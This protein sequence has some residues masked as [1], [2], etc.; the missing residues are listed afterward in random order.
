MSEM[1]S[2][3]VVPVPRVKSFST[4][5]LRAQRRQR[6]MK[7]RSTRSCFLKD[8]RRLR[9]NLDAFARE[10]A[11]EPSQQRARTVAIVQAAA[12]LLDKDIC[13]YD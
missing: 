4:T 7:A 1:R 8:I 11:D 6:E 12:N 2:V 13:S 9:D 5:D 10:Y 3:V